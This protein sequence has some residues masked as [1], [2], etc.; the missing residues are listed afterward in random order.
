MEQPMAALQERHAES[1][2]LFADLLVLTKAR[3]TTLVLLTTFVGFCMGS[4]GRLD[5][6]RLLNTLLGTGLVAASAAVLNQVLEARV[7]RLMERTR[8]R[9]LPAGRMERSTARKLG[10]T[11]AVLGL[12]HLWL[13][14]NLPSA[15]LAAATLLIY[16]F[17]YTPMKRKTSLCVVV[18][19][20]SGAIPPVIGWVAASPS[21]GMGALILFGVLFLWQMP[22]FRAIA[23][24]YRDEYAQAGFVMLQRNDCGGV[25]VARES[26]VYTLLLMFVALLPS[27]IGLAGPWYVVGAALCSG[28]FLFCAAQFLINRNRDMA[29]RLFFASILYL[30]SLLGLLLSA[31]A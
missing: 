19:A 15:A 21:F 30:P 7:D 25:R 2:S 31:R 20:V 10:I 16:L 3:L 8:N 9:P 28:G 14:V 17:L 6:L 4:E 13:A 24:M 5:W 26:F 1:G 12:A 22:H 11:M 18:G 27:T 23:W 29:R